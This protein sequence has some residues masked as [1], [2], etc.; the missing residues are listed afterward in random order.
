MQVAT[1]TEIK[2]QYSLPCNEYSF[3]HSE[4]INTYIKYDLIIEHRA[5]LNIHWSVYCHMYFTYTELM[6]MNHTEYLMLSKFLILI[7]SM[8][9]K[10]NPIAIVFVVC[11]NSIR[12]HELFDLSS[13]FSFSYN[14]SYEIFGSCWMGK[15]QQMSI[16]LFQN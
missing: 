1:H 12:K 10:T 6:N 14:V 8:S 11:K 3:Q 15:E 16:S 4:W 13:F 2:I 7:S 9:D 5:P